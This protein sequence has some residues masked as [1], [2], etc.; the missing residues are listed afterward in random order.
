ME[1]RR[2][3]GA[4]HASSTIV[5]LGVRRSPH[6]SSCTVARRRTPSSRTVAG[7]VAHAADPASERTM[8]SGPHAYM[9]AHRACIHDSAI[10]PYAPVKGVR[11]RC[12]RAESGSLVLWLPTGENVFNSYYL[13]VPVLYTSPCTT[14][15]WPKVVSY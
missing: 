4:A 15:G 5:A 1:H 6:H 11:A 7:G 13:R 3:L 2:P 8:Y 12:V 9:Y 14:L 10:V